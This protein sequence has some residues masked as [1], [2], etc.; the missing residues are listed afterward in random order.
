VIAA[1]LCSADIGCQP[2]ALAERALLFY[3]GAL[4]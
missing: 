4:K 3:C 1:A 2:E